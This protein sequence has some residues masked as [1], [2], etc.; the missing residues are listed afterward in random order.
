MPHF[1]QRNSAP[2]FAYTPTHFG[3]KK[4]SHPHLRFAWLTLPRSQLFVLKHDFLDHHRPEAKEADRR[5][6]T[7]KCGSP[8]HRSPCFGS[9]DRQSGLPLFLFDFEVFEDFLH[10]FLGSCHQHC[11]DESHRFLF[12]NA[13]LS[14]FLFFILALSSLCLFES[15]VDLR[16]GK[17]FEIHRIAVFWHHWF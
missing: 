13:F 7:K 10:C 12:Q 3:K 17:A 4:K 14:L 8:L 1:C 5:P 15:R 11:F 16:R 9:C 6:T 2:L